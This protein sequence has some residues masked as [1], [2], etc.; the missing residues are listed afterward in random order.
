MLHFNSQTQLVD[1]RD[2]QEYEDGHLPRAVSLS[3]GAVALD[4]ARE[5]PDR[6][7]PLAVYGAQ[8]NDE[9]ARRV[10]QT[11]RDL[12]YERVEVA[13]FGWAQWQASGGEVAFGPARWNVIN[14]CAG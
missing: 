9:A 11:L 14:P 13:D 5:L 2:E 12:G 1:A 8:G 6:S 3:A 10:A 4:A 7:Q